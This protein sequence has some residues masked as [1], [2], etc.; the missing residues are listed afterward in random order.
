MTTKRPVPS[1]LK[2]WQEHLSE[3]RKSNSGSSLKDAMRE[4]SKTY[5]KRSKSSSDIVPE[6]VAPAEAS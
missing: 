5:P 6:P 2:P 3:Y 1:S 4:A